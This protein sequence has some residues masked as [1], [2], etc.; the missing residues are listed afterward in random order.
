M[1]LKSILFLLAV[2]MARKVIIMPRS[3]FV[4]YCP[5]LGR[6]K[7]NGAYYDT[8]SLEAVLAHPTLAKFSLA[9]Q[10]VEQNTDCHM[11]ENREYWK[12]AIRSLTLYCRLSDIKDVAAIYAIKAN[13]AKASKKDKIISD[14]FSA[15][16]HCYE[17]KVAWLE[18]FTMLE[19]EGALNTM[20]KM[21][22]RFGAD[23]D[24]LL[25]GTKHGMFDAL[26]KERET[27][28]YNS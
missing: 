24:N 2:A 21:M 6:I 18:Y 16:I 4:E 28:Q 25:T 19:T 7:K 11:G 23:I 12:M 13:S 26:L 10:W 3:K 5:N 14:V 9:M 20:K 1:T 8:S 17:N 22:Q 27:F 15:F